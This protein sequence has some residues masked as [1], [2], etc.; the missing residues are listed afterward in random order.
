MR[1]LMSCEWWKWVRSGGYNQLFPTIMATIHMYIYLYIIGIYI[2]TLWSGSVSIFAKRQKLR[3][4]K[5]TP[6][7]PDDHVQMVIVKLLVLV[8]GIQP[9]LERTS[10]NDNTTSFYVD[11]VKNHLPIA[12]VLACISWGLESWIERGNELAAYWW[13]Y[14]TYQY[15]LW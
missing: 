3:R 12:D 5:P 9:Q 13:T 8:P 4:I 6:G 1:A 2:Y 11:M 7:P 15:S 14:M 10:P